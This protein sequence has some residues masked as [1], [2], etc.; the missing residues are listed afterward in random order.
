[1]PK[2]HGVSPH[3]Q[4]V[5]RFRWRET[6]RRMCRPETG[7]R[8]H[9][10]AGSTSGEAGNLTFMA[11]FGAR[12]EGRATSA[13]RSGRWRACM[14][15][16]TLPLSAPRAARFTRAARRGGRAVRR[17]RATAENRSRRG[18]FGSNFRPKARFQA[19]NREGA[20]SW[21]IPSK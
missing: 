4:P 20:V 19:G 12:R 7:R 5:R 13:R 17:G 16:R 8:E 15:E 11:P 14:R 21:A 6:R 9:C 1:M 10:E 2:Y 18:R 3:R